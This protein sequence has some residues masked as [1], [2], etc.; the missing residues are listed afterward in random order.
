[1][2]KHLSLIGLKPVL[3]ALCLITPLI[4]LAAS[5]PQEI[6]ELY[7]ADP[8]RGM[9][10][11]SPGGQLI[12]YLNRDG[13]EDMVLVYS[14][15]EKKALTGVRAGDMDLQQ[16]RFISDEYLILKASKERRIRGFRG[17]NEISTAYSLNVKTG[18]IEQLLRP[19]DVLYKGQLGLGR[20]L[21]VSPDRTK[22]YM[23]GF[24]PRSVSDL[25]PDYALLEVDVKNPRKPKV[26][27]EGHGLTY[28]WFVNSKGEVVAQERL[29]DETHRHSILVP[30]GRHWREIYVDESKQWRA[31]FAGLTADESA[32]VMLNTDPE[33]GRVT[34]YTLNLS[35]GKQ[36][37]LP[38]NRNDVDIESIETDANRVAMGVIYG[39]FNP[40]YHLFNETLNKRLADLQAQ[41]ESHSVWLVDTDAKR[42]NIIIFVAG[43]T[44][45]GS[46]YLSSPGKPLNYLMS[47]YPNIDTEKVHPT[48]AFRFKARDGLIIPTL[49]TIPRGQ[50]ADPKN[51]PAVIMPHGG[52]EAYDRQTF[53]DLAQAIAASGYAVIQPQFRGSSG[54]GYELWE[55]GLG[56]WG[57]AM[58]DD[59]SDA[60]TKLSNAGFVDASRVCILGTS[61]GGYAAL[62][63]ATF[64]PELYRCAVSIH[65]V[66]DLNQMIE[67]ERKE[68]GDDHWVVDYFSRSMARDYFTPERLA[69]HSPANFASGVQAPVLLVHGE[70]DKTVPIEQ[71]ELMH[72]NLKTA[73]KTVQYIELE[74]TG[75]SHGR[76]ETVRIPL[77]TEILQFLNQNLAP[78][79]QG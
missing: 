33:T 32:L 29:S 66:S 7:G 54:F 18:E 41:F 36:K 72:K 67:Y 78:D 74:D 5:E 61:Y 71:S 6:A 42:E 14:L 9:L 60:V 26:I 53:D 46:Y 69:A 1:M 31:H 2:L 12:A 24:V 58:Q 49:L 3:S 45:S 59:I 70:D 44:D 35:D 27:E 73:N 57:R 17:R 22:L 76:D 15:K 48:A 38:L 65:G 56:E 19:G 25:A 21:G 23:P 20:V 52:P 43:P 11:L 37:K 4:S 64:T 10:S 63:G 62:A 75:H 47:A 55:A 51:L 16:L 40:K 68:L 30:D 79:T 8:S 34:Y 28:D 77:Y 13:D 39:G 50:A